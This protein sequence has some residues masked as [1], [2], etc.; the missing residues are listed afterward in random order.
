MDPATK[1][2]VHD[3]EDWGKLAGRKDLCKHVGKFFLS[4]PKDEALTRLDAIAADRDAWTFSTPT[5]EVSRPYPPFQGPAA[6]VNGRR[7]VDA[8][9]ASSSHPSSSAIRRRS[10]RFTAARLRSMGIWNCTSFC[11]L[12]ALGMGRHCRIPGVGSPPTSTASCSEPRA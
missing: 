10:R 5:A 4:L 3:C 9:W 2:I 6:K 8:W 12:C 11:R 7:G 1:T